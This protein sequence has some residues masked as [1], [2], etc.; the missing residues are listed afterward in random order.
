MGKPMLSVIVTFYNQEKYVDQALKSIMTQKTKF[1]FEVLVADDGSE[2]GTVKKVQK[3]IDEYPNQIKLFIMPRDKTKKYFGSFRFCQ[4][5]LYLLNEVQGKYFANLD[6]DDYFIDEMK[7][8]KQV[9]ILERE[10][11]KDC[12]ACA[13]DMEKLYPD[14][15]KK[16]ICAGRLKER[17]IG[18]REY[19]KNYY[20]PAESF[21]IRSSVI[22]EIPQEL[23]KNAFEDIIQTFFILKYGKIYYIPRVM[24][25][26]VQTGEGLWTVGDK[27]LN[28]V[29]NMLRY[30][31]AIQLW[32][33]MK[34]ITD[35][36]LS[37]VWWGIF[38]ERKKLSPDKYPILYR[39]ACNKELKYS[40][41]WLQ[42][43][44]L[45]F[46]SK[47]SLFFLTLCKINLEKYKTKIIQWTINRKY[48]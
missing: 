38:R 22:K 4:A 28:N 47:C 2:D 15:S 21:I 9:E 42:Y 41:M 14:G 16:R 43:N 33:E 35:K 6:G 23:V 46:K 30:D 5:R 19:W 10:E 27:T 20:L 32:P 34:T 39:E 24:A 13:H 29:S 48:K 12:I 37:S 7:F 45:D 17:K 31:I 11:N 44:S 1:E 25:V 8:Q 26:Y 18:A 36:K 40:R 3:W